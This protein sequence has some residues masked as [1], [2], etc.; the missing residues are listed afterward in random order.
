MRPVDWWRS[1]VARWTDPLDDSAAGRHLQRAAGVQ[2]GSA[3]RGVVDS[4]RRLLGQPR[5]TSACVRQQRPAT[6]LW[7]I[8]TVNE[9]DTVNRVPARG[10]SMNGPGATI[11]GGML[12]VNSG[13]GSLGFMPG[14]VVLAFSIDGK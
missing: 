5:R 13:Y 4:W 8:N 12:F 6:V 11:A 1:N 9:Y 3:G 14:N 2:H 7:D 10:G